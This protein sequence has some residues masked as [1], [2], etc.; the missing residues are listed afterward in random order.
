[1]SGGEWAAVLGGAAA[2]ITA[3]AQLVRAVRQGKPSQPP[4]EPDEPE[5]SKE[6]STEVER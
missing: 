5:G 2:V 6:T 4:E 1:V 3:T